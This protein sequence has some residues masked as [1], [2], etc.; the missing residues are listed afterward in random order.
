MLSFQ[1]SPE[2]IS[3]AYRRQSRLYHPDKHI[4]PVLKKEA[5]ILFNRTKKAYEGL[6]SFLSYFNVYC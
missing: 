4:D 2:D 1:A 3:N 6:Y 5:E